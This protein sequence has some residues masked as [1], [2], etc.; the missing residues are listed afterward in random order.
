MATPI[1]NTPSISGGDS[2]RFNEYISKNSG[3]K[4]SP[5]RYREMTKIVKKVEVRK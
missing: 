1:K 4:I 5:E 3:N 2:K